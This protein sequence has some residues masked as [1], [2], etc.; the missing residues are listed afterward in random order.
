MNITIRKATTADATVI[1]EHDRWVNK[2]TIYEKIE[3]EQLYVAF[4]GDIFAGWMRYSLFWD[5]TPFMNMLH[6]LPEFRGKGIG[7]MMVSFWEEEMQSQGYK[8]L[9]TST[10]QNETAQHFYEK[11]GYKAIGG[12]IL[13]SEPLEIIFSK[14]I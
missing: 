1:A 2:Q 11:L 6:F 12:F 5:N 7:K 10:A 9:L 4:Y 14:K 13:E 8:I 3:K